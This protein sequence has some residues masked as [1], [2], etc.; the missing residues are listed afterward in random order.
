MSL[1][2]EDDLAVPKGLCLMYHYLVLLGVR[3]SLWYWMWVRV[4]PFA[5]SSDVYPWNEVGVVGLLH[6]ISY[7][8]DSAYH[9]RGTDRTFSKVLG[10]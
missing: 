8:S 5:E 10:D 1:T 6:A 2:I 4:I 3:C 7:S 9:D